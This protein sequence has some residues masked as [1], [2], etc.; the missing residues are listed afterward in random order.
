MDTVVNLAPVYEGGGGQTDHPAT[1][2]RVRHRERMITVVGNI[3][4]AWSSCER[5]T[6]LKTSRIMIVPN[7]LGI[8]VR[9]SGT[10]IG[11]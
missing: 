3:G 5:H 4:S 6:R 2:Q 9:A 1:T 7:I 11:L 8:A 10:W